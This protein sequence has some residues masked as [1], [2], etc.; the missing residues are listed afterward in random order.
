MLTFRSEEIAVALGL[1]AD[2]IAD[3]ANVELSADNLAADDLVIELFDQLQGRLLLYVRSFGLPTQDSED[4]LQE[5]FL[6][7]F[8]HLMHGRSR[9][10]LRGW[11]FRVC[12]NLALKRRS[13][14]KLS[15]VGC[16]AGYSADRKDSAPTPHDLL[17]FREEHTLYA[18]VLDALP[19]Q[20]RCCLLL[21][22]EGLKYREISALVGMSLGSV[23][24][25]ISRSLARFTRAA[26]R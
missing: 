1:P 4:V 13:S 26:E 22:A 5:A 25:S 8:K 3:A 10:N 18:A 14:I 19:E 15:G 20:D 16:F 7:L 12:H 6:S 17:E 11:L 9:A 21:R 24:T 23:C 2:Q